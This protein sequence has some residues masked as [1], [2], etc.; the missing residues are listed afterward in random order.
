VPY[1]PHKLTGLGLTRLGTSEAVALGAYA[2]ALGR[3]DRR[4]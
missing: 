1:T 2:V 3:L 4:P